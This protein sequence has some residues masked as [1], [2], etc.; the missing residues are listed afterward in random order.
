MSKATA[1]RSFD[2]NTGAFFCILQKM[3]GRLKRVMNRGLTI[4]IILLLLVSKTLSAQE[5]FIDPP[6]KQ[7]TKIKFTQLT[8]GVVIIKALLDG[9]SDSLSFILDTGSGGISLDSSTVADLGLAPSTPERIIRGIGGT[10]K[11]GFLRNRTLKIGEL[12]ID[13][14]NF[15]VV[16]YEVLSSLYGEKIDGIIGYSVF[17]RYILKINY[18]EFE[19]GFWTNGTIKYPRGG[20]LL[21]P[22]INPLP[23]SAARIGDHRSIGFNYLFDIGAGLTVLFSQDFVDDSLF[24]KVKR[25]RY[26]KQGEGLGGK[27]D[28][29]L[30]VMKELRIGPYRFKNV[31]INIFDDEYNV[32]SYPTLGG[33][34]GNEIFRRFNCILN[35]DKR[36]IHL[37]PNSHFRDPFDYAYSGIELYLIDGKIL[38]GVVPKGSPAYNA[39]IKEGDEIIGVNHRLGLNINDLKQE[40]QSTSGTVKIIIRRN[41]ELSTVTMKVINILNGKAQSTSSS[42]EGILQRKNY[43]IATPPTL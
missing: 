11:V 1:K 14:L 33:L 8:G 32:T 15:H 28:M 2:S 21:R 13:S 35:Y 25:T 36:Q 29:Y 24:L 16:D 22:R 10:R 31:P 37:L 30:S 26:L 23:L 7:L 12:K 18:D 39:G 43:R 17:S 9:F 19:V 4:L 40:L 38:T 42:T 20:F 27:V 6:S 5:E 3:A 34:V 41:E